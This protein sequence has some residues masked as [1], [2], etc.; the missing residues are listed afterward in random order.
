M[1]SFVS[2]RIDYC[3]SLL[4]HAPGYQID[5]LQRVLNAAARLVLQLSRYEH[6]LRP[7]VRDNLHWLRVP[8]RID[9]KLCTFVYKSLHSTAPQH[10]TDFANL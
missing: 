1:H 10:L 5:Q 2:N 4:A 3:N 7:L 8:E 9:Y 6:N